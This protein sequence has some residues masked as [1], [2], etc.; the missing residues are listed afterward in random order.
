MTKPLESDLHQFFYDLHQHPELSNNEF[1]TTQKIKKALDQYHIKVLDLP[2]KTGLVAEIG[3]GLPFIVLRGDID[4]LPIQEEVDVSY[5]SKNDGVMHACGH[6]FHATAMLGTAILLKEREHTLEGTVRIIFQA[7][8]EVGTGALDV[9]RTGVLDQAEVVFGI[10]NDPT[11]A[12]GIIGCKA[13]ALT[14]GVDRF[15]IRIQAKG[16]HAARPQ[17]GNDP[18][19]VVAHIIQ[20]FQTIISRRISSDE[21]A[22]VSL[23]Q[24]HS[25]TTW[26][27]IPD[28]AFLE[29]TVRSFNAQT[30]QLIENEIRQI[31]KGI[32]QTFAV[33]IDL[34]WQAGPPSVTN[35]SIWSNFALQVAKE[36]NLKY[37]EIEKSP[38]G[39]DFSFYQEKV[40]GA[41]IMIGSG[42]PYPLHHPKF[43]IDTN[44]VFPSALYLSN[45][46]ESALGFLQKKRK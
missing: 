34:D 42:G 25:G 41:F 29:G 7:A 19:I 46:A 40:A 27:I 12:S 32:E 22:V 39:E 44:I 1:E 14:A 45:L 30:R 4:A 10:H 6:D 11:L 15:A 13:G 5:I 9:I 8:E 21:N 2:L 28:T 16:T 3:Q 38:I 17:D 24:V 43:K 37:R 35:D 26:N 31:L 36:S 33:K 18:L 20:I 23:T